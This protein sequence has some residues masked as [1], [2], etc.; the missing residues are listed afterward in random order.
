MSFV[1]IST[2]TDVP[3]LQVKELRDPVVKDVVRKRLP[4]KPRSDASEI[5]DLES[6]SDRDNDNDEH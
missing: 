6:T 3:E 5:R 2:Y 1:Y 4:Q